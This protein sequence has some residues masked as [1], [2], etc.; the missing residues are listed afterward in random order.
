M[1]SNQGGNTTGGC[2]IERGSRAVV[3]EPM[4]LILWQ[5]GTC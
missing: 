3:G 2:S 5:H 1:E 4:R